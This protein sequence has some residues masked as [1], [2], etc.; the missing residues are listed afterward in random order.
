MPMSPLELM[1]QEYQRINQQ[2]ELANQAR[3]MNVLDFANTF[4]NSDSYKVDP[5]FAGFMGS[6]GAPGRPPE[7]YFPAMQNQLK[8]RADADAFYGK[9]VEDY[10]SNS[11]KELG[12]LQ[13]R[14]IAR[15]Q[16]SKTGG[17]NGFRYEK[18]GDTVNGVYLVDRMGEESAKLVVPPAAFAKEYASMFKDY[19]QQIIGGGVLTN[20]AEIDAEAR[21]QAL[22]SLQ[23]FMELHPQGS[24]AVPTTRPAIDGTQAVNSTTGVE[25]SAL[26][27]IEERSYRKQDD[28]G[29]TFQLEDPE[30]RIA[31][32]TAGA[33]LEPVHEDLETSIAK[34]NL[35]M[36]EAEIARTRDP[37]IK[38]ELTAEKNAIQ[39]GI[40]SGA[41]STPIPQSPVPAKTFLTPQEKQ[42]QETAGKMEFEKYSKSKEDLENVRK[43]NESMRTMEGIITSGKNTS[44]QAHEFMN[45]LGGYL[46]YIDPKGTLAQ[47]V[48]NDAAYFANMMNLVRDKIKALGAGTAVS[49]LDLI[50]TQ[51]S[52]GD[53]RNTPQGNL[54]VLA[55]MKLANA[56]MQEIGE[57]GVGYYDENGS[58]K[59]FKPGNDPT[60]AIRYKRINAGGR[61]NLMNFEIESKDEWIERVRQANNGK[62]P[63]QATLDSAWKKYADDSVKGMFNVQ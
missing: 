58:Y 56:T 8:N 39:A 28:L 32:G 20:P 43:M 2:R 55:L 23:Q 62:L 4:R 13:E 27:P 47:S 38:A 44:G 3:A 60:H 50:T 61:E 21:R 25:T 12:D 41:G 57:R 11:Q 54:K 6:M 5:I 7:G 59:G 16:A 17:P 48:G 26:P 49:N 1:M 35:S 29:A 31:A 37:K 9:T 30:G 63:P 19:K 14:L 33:T 15:M 22:S 40:S 45:K 53:L 46:N 24:T 18:A 34:T 52:V 42:A 10:L 36:L 51:K